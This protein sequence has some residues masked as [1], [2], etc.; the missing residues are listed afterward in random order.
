MPYFSVL[1]TGTL[2]LLSASLGA[3]A[4]THQEF[5]CAGKDYTESAL[6]GTG[7]S[8]GFVTCTYAAAG[9][10]AYSTD[11]YFST[12]SSGCPDGL[13]LVQDDD[14]EMHA[15]ASTICPP[16][17]D[18][19]STLIGSGVSGKFKTCTYSNAGLC[20]YFS[21]GLFTSGGSTCPDTIVPSACACSA[22]NTAGNSSSSS[23]SSG[24]SAH[25]DAVVA[26]ASAGDSGESG[27][28][29]GTRP[30]IIALLALNGVLVLITLVLGAMLIRARR[31][32]AKSV[33]GGDGSRSLYY[34]DELDKDSASVPLTHGTYHDPH[35]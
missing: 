9:Q 16:S 27:G 22:S 3:N 30:E 26:A 15:A 19:G 18:A 13:S 21:H 17:D 20:V 7:R 34:S 8:G 10:C 31:T 6:I 11:G 14:G 23:S 29:S 35:E 33:Q 32:A 28:G 4:A 5:E 12:G 2:A 25:G 24:P 1:L